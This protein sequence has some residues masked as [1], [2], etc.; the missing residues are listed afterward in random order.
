MTS[1]GCRA[2]L[3]EAGLAAVD[4]VDRVAFVAEH[5]AE[6]GANAGFVVDDQ[7]ANGHERQ[8]AGSSD[9][10]SCVPLGAAAPTSMPPPCSTTMRRTIASPRPLPRPF[11]E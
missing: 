8:A 11:V 9:G 1:Y 5:A 10:E 3:I 4:G 7:N 6:R 2:D